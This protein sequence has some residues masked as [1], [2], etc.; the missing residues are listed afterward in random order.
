MMALVMVTTAH[1]TGPQAHAD[2]IFSTTGE[3]TVST[4]Q[5]H[6]YTVIGDGSYDFDFNFVPEEGTLNVINGG[7]LTTYEL[8]AGY[9]GVGTL[10]VNGGTINVTVDSYIGYQY[11]GTATVSS[12]SWATGGN[13]YIGGTSP[14]YDSPGVLNISGGTVTVSRDLTRNS[15]STIN[16]NTGGTL[17]IG[18]GG[19]TGTLLGGTGNLTNNGT[20]IFNRS[21]AYSYS[22]VLSGSGTLVQQG[23]GT[24][25]LS[26]SSNYGGETNVSA[27]TLELD[28]DGALTDTSGVNINGGTLLLTNV[29]D[30][31]NHAAVISLGATTGDSILRLSGN[32]SE[33]LGGMTLAGGNAD[34]RV[35]D[36][37]SGDG[38]LSMENLTG[39]SSQGLEIWNWTDGTDHLYVNS[40]S[41]WG[42]LTTSN[43]SFFS[44]G[45]SSLIGTA[46]FTSGSNELVPSGLVPVPEASTLLGVLG[47]MAPLAWRERRHWMRCREAR[48]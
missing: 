10:N 29:S 45:G 15:A 21:D 17:Q 24:L 39:S 30:R 44:D 3:G 43:I 27:G 47:L 11:N 40:G 4:V 1:L 7:I 20:L 35:I 37:G 23:T 26:G 41:L 9:Q 38:Y 36:F 6:T 31:I 34:R 13:L 46:Q 22:G 16:L 28:G 48:G 32:V 42:T 18:T 12:G 8:I 19:N 2:F 25:T 33:A 14:G 5:S